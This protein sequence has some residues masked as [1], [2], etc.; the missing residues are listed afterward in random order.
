MVFARSVG[1]SSCQLSA[2]AL[3]EIFTNLVNR[4]STTSAT[5]TITGNFG[6]AT[7]NTSIATAKNWVVVN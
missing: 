4:T 3:N 1:L 2:T 6:A 5:I 7:A